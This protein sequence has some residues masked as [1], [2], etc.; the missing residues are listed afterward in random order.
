MAIAE[1]YID[2]FSNLAKANNTMLL[3]AETGDVSAMV[4]K[5][6]GPSFSF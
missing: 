1:R 3:S 6:R 5:V 4:A 2:T